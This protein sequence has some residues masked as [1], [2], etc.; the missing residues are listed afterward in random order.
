MSSMFIIMQVI[1]PTIKRTCFENAILMAELEGLD[2][3][4]LPITFPIPVTSQDSWHVPSEMLGL[5]QH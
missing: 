5:L 1:I 3:L 2:G 4:F